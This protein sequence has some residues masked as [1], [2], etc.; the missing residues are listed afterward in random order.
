MLCELTNLIN[1]TYLYTKE[2]HGLFTVVNQITKYV[3]Y[4]FNC[5]GLD[6]SVGG[7]GGEGQE[8][9][10]KV[11]Q[12]FTDFRSMVRKHAIAKDF[13]EVLKNCDSIRDDIMPFLGI[14]I[15]D[16]AGKEFSVCKFD[17]PENLIKARDL[18][19]KQ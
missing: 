11:V 6:F 17:E 1:L 18:K 13:V 9:L 10:G 16:I 2:G 15:E 14:R 4:I 3:Y 19:I 12:A 7:A 8:H 5:M